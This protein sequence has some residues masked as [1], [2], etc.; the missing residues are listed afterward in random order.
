MIGKPRVLSH[1]HAEPTQLDLFSGP[2]LH[3]ERAIREL[4]AARPEAAAAALDVDDR[5]RRPD[6]WQAL[7]ELA[8]LLRQAL[9]DAVVRADGP[10]AAIREHWLRIEALAKNRLSWSTEIV[11]T[12]GRSL[13]SRI[14]EHAPNPLPRLLP[15]GTHSGW[16]LLNAGDAPGAIAAL[17][18][19]AC[20]TSGR[21]LG[22]L[23]DALFEAGRRADSAE[24]YRE[25]LYLDPCGIDLDGLRDPQLRGVLLDDAAELGPEWRLPSACLAAILPLG[26][27]GSVVAGATAREAYTQLTTRDLRSLANVERARLFYRGMVLGDPGSR[28][29]SDLGEIRAAM[30][31]ANANLFDAYMSLLRTRPA[32]PL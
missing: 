31:A 26:S 24:M 14:V 21:E 9:V 11:A 23:A 19:A 25:A 7:C 1:M 29:Q 18:E 3:R 13:F 32:P 5:S 15:D 4:L 22:T 20:G 16:L 30:K 8:S 28:M 27:V 10:A 12:L 17:R 6:E 2:H